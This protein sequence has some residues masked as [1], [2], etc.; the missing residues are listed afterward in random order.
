MQPYL[1]SVI[2]PAYN[3]EKY[4]AADIGAIRR[5]EATLGAP[6][7]MVVGDTM[8]TAAMAESLGAHVA[9]I[10]ERNI[11]AVRNGA[12]DTRQ[13]KKIDRPV[14]DNKAA[15]AALGPAMFLFLR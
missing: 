3:E 7:E 15:I 11:S 10:S 9:R 1:F 5:A 2:I 14:T 4:L 13:G 6:V 8:I 12:G